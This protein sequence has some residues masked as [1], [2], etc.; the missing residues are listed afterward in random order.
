LVGRL[1]LFER[2]KVPLDLKVLGLAMYFQALGG[3]LAFYLSTAVFLRLL[4]GLLSLGEGTYSAKHS[5][6]TTTILEGEP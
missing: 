2:N 3:L 5:H 1:K 6:T 4:F